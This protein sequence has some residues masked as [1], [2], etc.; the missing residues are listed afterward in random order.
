MQEI[1]LIGY[2]FLTIILLVVTIFHWKNLFLAITRIGNMEKEFEAWKLENDSEK[3]RYSLIETEIK[4]NAALVAEVKKR[5]A[6]VEI[7][8]L[9][10]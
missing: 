2:I 3:K 6:E 4:N 1:A 10:R 9:R 8:K 7:N 5:L